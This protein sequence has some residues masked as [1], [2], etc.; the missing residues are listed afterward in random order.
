MSKSPPDLSANPV[1]RDLA[2]LLRIDAGA[3]LGTATR[4]HAVFSRI[5]V[6]AAGRRRRDLGLLIGFPL[7]LLLGVVTV[8]DMR[9]DSSLAAKRDRGER[10]DTPIIAASPL[11]RALAPSP[12]RQPAAPGRPKDVYVARNVSTAP[13]TRYDRPR[14]KMT[15][16]FTGKGAQTPV[17]SPSER[18]RFDVPGDNSKSQPGEEPRNEVMV[19]VAKVRRVTRTETIDDIRFLKLQ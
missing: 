9:G 8:S 7:A 19:D 18:P 14:S 13:A 17:V 11:A 1:E 15:S 4:D 3:S 2:A 12:V 6:L 16:L 5:V 10:I